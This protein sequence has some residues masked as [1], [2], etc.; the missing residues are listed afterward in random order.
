MSGLVFGFVL[1]IVILFMLG[2]LLLDRSGSK[3]V[4]R[5]RQWAAGRGW[6]VT[7][8]PAVEWA[9]RLPGEKL[10]GENRRGVSLLVSGMV[11]GWAVGVADYSYEEQTNDGPVTYHFVVT[12]VRLDE[13]YPPLAVR[14]RGALARSRLGRAVFGA[15]ATATGHEAFDRKFR[16]QIEDPAP[17]RTLLGPK[18]IAEHL[19]GRA[20]AW[21]LDG[22]DLLTWQAG[23]IKDPDQIPALASRLVRV[24]ELLGR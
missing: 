2:P 10:P 11:D 19:A 13:P 18:L 4:E 20:P 5:I 9:V 1:V 8:R 12:S 24:A 23:R 14:P 22:Q 21:S 3:R 6:T 15:D 17:A 16:V 7:E